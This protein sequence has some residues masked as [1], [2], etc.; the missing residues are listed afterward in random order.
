MFVQKVN[1]KIIQTGG[2][3]K[4]KISGRGQKLNWAKITEFFVRNKSQKCFTYCKPALVRRILLHC[5][6]FID[7]VGNGTLDPNP[8][9]HCSITNG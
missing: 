8:F 4:K 2:V 5:Y 7:H 9:A 6:Q 3:C 1:Y